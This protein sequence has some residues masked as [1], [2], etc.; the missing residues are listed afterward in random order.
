MEARLNVLRSGSDVERTIF[1]SDAVFAIAMTLLVLELRVPEASADVSA[2]AFA[3]AVA[4]KV[5]AFIAFVLSFVII[6]LTWLTHHRRFKALAAY[7][8]RLQ[9][10]NLGMLFFVA[11]MPVPT[12]MLFQHSGGSPIPP[13]LYAGTIVGIFGMLD[14]AWW[15]AW[16][17]GLLKAEVTPAL[18]RFTAAALRPALLVFLLSIPLALISP[19]GAEY[20]WLTLWPLA[21]LNGRWQ[22][23]RFVRAETSATTA[24]GDPATA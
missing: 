13:M 16:R 14:L 4:E 19:N 20:A 22:K 8:T 11:F 6:G 17:S 5:P 23:R 18:Y 10:A 9:L 24:T 7:D 1:F 2:H 3:E 12:G 21:A 15:H